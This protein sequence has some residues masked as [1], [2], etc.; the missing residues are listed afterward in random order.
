VRNWKINMTSCGEKESEKEVQRG[1]REKERKRE[2]G[3]IR[4]SEI[5]REENIKKDIRRPGEDR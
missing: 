2:S 4:V 5:D 1:K 3:I